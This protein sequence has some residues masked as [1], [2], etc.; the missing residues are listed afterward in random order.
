MSGAN[1]TPLLVRVRE[2]GL[3]LRADRGN[4]IYRPKD[5][6]TPELREQLLRHKPDLLELLTWRESTAHALLKDAMSY[7]A[8]FYVAGSDLAA[9]D[10][11]EERI[12]AAFH[13]RDMFALRVAVREWKREGVRMFNRNQQKGTAA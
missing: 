2:A 7:L 13:D 11:H 3:T 6:L 8:E 4:L 5:K 9:L 1:L 12:D 10:P